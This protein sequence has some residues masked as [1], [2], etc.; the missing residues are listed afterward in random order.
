MWEREEKEYK[1]T[2]KS[3][4]TRKLFQENSGDE[5]LIQEHRANDI[6]FDSH[7]CQHLKMI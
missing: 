7:Q 6:T 3:W 4:P 1:H 2:A 5:E